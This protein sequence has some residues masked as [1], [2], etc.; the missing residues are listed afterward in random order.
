MRTLFK[1]ILPLM[2]LFIVS[3]LLWGNEQKTWSVCPVLL[4]VLYM[5][6]ADIRIDGKQIYY[7][8][9]VSWKKLPDD[10]A[11]IRCSLFPALGYIRFR[12]FLPPFGLLVF[13][14]ERGS[15]RFIP[16]HR[17]AFMT[18][19]LSRS[20]PQQ[21]EMSAKSEEEENEATRSGRLTS[22]LLPVM[23]I[24]IGI[25][26]PVPWQH[27]TA[28]VDKGLL[29]RFLQFQQYPA[30][31]SCYAGVLVLLILWNRFRSFVNFGLAFLIGT[32]IAHL[33]HL[34]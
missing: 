14:V 7:R 1:F 19:M 28:P 4:I 24:L 31:M 22:V 13:I 20:N 33:G 12:H 10:I 11:D 27:W 15:G 3:V 29:S 6:S 17:T 21:N 16:F 26:I 5:S 34:H 18:T 8:H 32:I 2:G 25:L 9:F 30:V 23:G